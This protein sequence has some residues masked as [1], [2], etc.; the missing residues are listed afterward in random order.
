MEKLKLQIRTGLEGLVVVQN[1][2]AFNL[3]DEIESS[4]TSASATTAYHRA[5][6]LH[7]GAL[8]QL[9][10]VRAIQEFVA[11]LLDSAVLS[12]INLLGQVS[13]NRSHIATLY[14]RSADDICSKAEVGLCVLYSLLP[15]HCT[16]QCQWQS[17]FLSLY[18]DVCKII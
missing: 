9:A 6:Q 5:F 10:S 8:A 4:N 16:Y 14:A 13:T 1:L 18:T 7:A 17:C 3:H 15:L 12:R 2:T 11:D